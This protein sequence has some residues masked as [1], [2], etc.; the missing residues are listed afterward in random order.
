M[1]ENIQ[2]LVFDP[3]LMQEKGVDSSVHGNP[4]LQKNSSVSTISSSNLQ[5]I[6]SKLSRTNYSFWK[7]QVLSNVANHD[8]EEH[9]IRLL[10]QPTQ[11]IQV[12][13]VDPSSSSVLVKKTNP[14]YLIWKKIDRMLICWLIASISEDIFP[15][16]S[17][18]H[19]TTEIWNSLENEFL[20]ASKTRMLHVKNLLQTTKKG[21]FNVE[22]YVSKMKGYIETL[23]SGKQYVS[24][25]ELINHIL[26]GLGPEFEAIV[27]SLVTRIESSSEKLS[28]QDV[29]YI[30]Q[31]HEMR[32]AKTNNALNSVIAMDFHSSSTN[33]TSLTKPQI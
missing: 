1:M 6:S 2:V 7:Y 14:E 8:L 28:V 16:V 11:F 23:E 13:S 30:L 26:D 12:R 27:S 22:S 20:N 17:K 10:P 33:A 5:V 15:I 4:N 19:T 25:I 24:D 18:C 29:V 9:L 3:S 21:N 31:K 32:L